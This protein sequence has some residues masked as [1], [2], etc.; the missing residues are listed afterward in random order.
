MDS[1]LE[2]VGLLGM[3]FAPV[4]KS[5]ILAFSRASD[6]HW[7]QLTSG[8]TNVHCLREGV[9]D[10]NILQIN[11]PEICPRITCSA[12]QP[13]L[14]QNARLA[15]KNGGCQSTPSWERPGAP[16]WRGHM[17]TSQPR[18]RWTTNQE[19]CAPLSSYPLTCSRSRLMS[20][21]RRTQ[22]WCVGYHHSR[23]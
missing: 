11:P 7:P 12:V 19:Q 5:L 16:R 23:A 22:S 20:C 10:W 18:R 4:L 9:E 2:K 21:A 1:P 6:L 13:T 17:V 15:R 8:K 3:F 14:C